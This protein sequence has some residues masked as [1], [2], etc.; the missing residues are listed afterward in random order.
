MS[1]LRVMRDYNADNFL[2][3]GEVLEIE[4]RAD[5][6][7]LIDRRQGE[8]RNAERRMKDRRSDERRGNYKAKDASSISRLLTPEE[9]DSVQRLFS[10]LFKSKTKK[11]KK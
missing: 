3:S 6:R 7:R 9:R 2:T 8:R 5:E 11:T 4:R 1:R 10:N